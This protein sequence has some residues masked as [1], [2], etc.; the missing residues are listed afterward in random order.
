M[1]LQEYVSSTY[2]DRIAE[3]YDSWYRDEPDTAGTVEAL[4]RL[5]GPGP[6][7]ELGIGTGR[8]AIPLVERGIEVH[9]IEL[10][11]PMVERLREKPLGRDIPVAMGDFGDVA[12]E[13]RYSL[14]FCVF[15]TFFCLPDQESQLRSTWPASS[16]ASRCASARRRPTTWSW[17]PPG[18]TRRR[19]RW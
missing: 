14:V 11:E 5:A 12:V 10:S 8:I 19:R 4:T 3:L 18:W 6:V 17:W 13:G 7:L 16:A 9:G 2:G 15:S 1:A